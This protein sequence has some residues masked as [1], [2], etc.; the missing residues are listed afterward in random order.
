[1]LRGESGCNVTRYS[2]SGACW[3]QWPSYEDMSF[4]VTIVMVGAGETFS[5]WA[6]YP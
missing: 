3:D 2:V 1:M 6:S 4:R 5:G